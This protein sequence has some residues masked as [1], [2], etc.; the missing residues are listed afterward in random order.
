MR[1]AAARLPQEKKTPLEE[2]GRSDLMEASAAM[3]KVAAEINEVTRQQHL[4][5][6][7][8]GE[9]RLTRSAPLNDRL[10]GLPFDMD[11]LGDLM[12]DF[13]EAVLVQEKQKTSPRRV[14]VFRNYLMGCKR[15]EGDEL[16]VKELYE[17]ANCRCVANDR[18]TFAVTPIADPADASVYSVKNI[19]VRSRLAWL[20]DESTA[21]SAALSPLPPAAAAPSGKKRVSASEA[22]DPGDTQAAEAGGGEATADAAAAAAT[23]D[24]AAGGSAAASGPSSLGHDGTPAGSAAAGER[25]GT[26]ESVD[27]AMPLPEGGS[28]SVTRKGRGLAS[29]LV[30]AR[31]RVF[32][33]GKQYT[34]RG[35]APSS[36]DGRRSG[37]SPTHSHPEP[38]S[39]RLKLEDHRDSRESMTDAPVDEDD[40]A[41]LP[42]P[43]SRVRTGGGGGGAGA[44]ARKGLT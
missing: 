20:F 21:R 2:Q 4:S 31:D 39:P 32:S 41:E 28:P 44:G 9:I 25:R 33:T 10:T 29:R 1:P 8:Y 30:A 5:E 42:S 3:K 38:R 16:T 13:A 6:V 14:L 37:P 19:D 23:G 12:D 17:L 26:G 22:S 18:T 43:T 36:A 35:L 24:D 11:T 34:P 15:R 7:M 27:L 40:D